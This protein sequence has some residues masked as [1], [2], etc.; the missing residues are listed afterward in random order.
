MNTYK[1]ALELDGE[2]DARYEENDFSHVG[3]K[4]VIGGDRGDIYFDGF[5]VEAGKTVLY[6]PELRTSLELTQEEAQ[7]IAI[8]VLHFAYE[9]I[10]FEC[11]Y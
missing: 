4:R 7:D 11:L 8:E 10:G 5:D 2:A 6:K 3:Q 9:A 1:V